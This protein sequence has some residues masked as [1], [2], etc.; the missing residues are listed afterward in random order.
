MT[1][2]SNEAGFTVVRDGYDPGEVEKRL[3]ELNTLVAI[4]TN[5]SA[6]LER[7]LRTAVAEATDLLNRLDDE[8]T[9]AAYRTQ[10]EVDESAG[11]GSAA[12]AS[13]D[14]VPDA[15]QPAPN[16][17]PSAAAPPTGAAAPPDRQWIAGTIRE[18]SPT[19]AGATIWIVPEDQPHSVVSIFFA[20]EEVGSDAVAHVCATLETGEAVRVWHTDRHGLTIEQI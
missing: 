11:T 16:H 6:A 14:P 5:R 17:P 10:H 1:R 4:A 8:T 20:N 19:E 7:L 3:A 12:V 18:I 15:P 9:V 13:P 2:V